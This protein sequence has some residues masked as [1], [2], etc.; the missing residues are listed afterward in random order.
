MEQ[1][2]FDDEAMS[3][4][5]VYKGCSEYQAGRERVEDKERPG[6]P[7]TSTDEAH[8]QQIKDLVLKTS[9][10]T[11]RDLA[12]EVGI[13]KGS[14]NTILKDVLGLKRVKSRLVPKTLN[15]LE[16]RRQKLNPYRSAPTTVFT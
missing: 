3:K 2:A 10:L 11:I 8:V 15:F 6:R 5:N 9:R 1:K 13:S 7:S 16:K 4:E 14:A 12:D